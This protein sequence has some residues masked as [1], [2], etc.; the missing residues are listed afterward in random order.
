MFD[1][2]K[3][4][5]LAVTFLV[6]CQ[7]NA[8]SLAEANEVR[9]AI[10]AYTQSEDYQTPE[11]F[12]LVDTSEYNGIT[13]ELKEIYDSANHFDYRRT[14]W[15]EDGE[16]SESELWLFFDGVKTYTLETS[17]GGV[18]T[19]IE[20]IGNTFDE[21]R[22]YSMTW[23]ENWNAIDWYAEKLDSVTEENAHAKNVY[24]SKGD[25]HLYYKLYLPMVAGGF[26]TM[27]LLF[28]NYNLVRYA[29]QSSEATESYLVD[30]K[31]APTTYP[32]IGSFTL[33]SEE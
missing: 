6:A 5:L 4:S 21:L 17:A 25:G 7:A 15:T 3:L 8:I 2:R 11:K 20:D 12:T 9:D 32:D 18:K 31:N 19:R 14:R 24:Q 13:L 29:T 28:E 16:T 26:Q 22:P 30:Y 23:L 10:R 27:E 1:R 33:T